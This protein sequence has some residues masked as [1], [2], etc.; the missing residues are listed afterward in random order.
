MQDI[1][2]ALQIEVRH[3]LNATRFMPPGRER[4][5]ELRLVALLAASRRLLADR[6]Q[7]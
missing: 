4:D 1:V 7:A 6:V 5:Q 3:R 2:E